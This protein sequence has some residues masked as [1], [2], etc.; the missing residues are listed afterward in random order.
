MAWLVDR[1]KGLF[2]SGKFD[3]DFWDSLEDLLIEAD[4]GAE[5]VFELVDELKKRS[6]RDRAVTQDDVIEILKDSVSSHIKAY[7]FYI[8]DNDFCVFLFLG[9]NG[10]GK[11][12]SIAKFSHYLKKTYDRSDIVLAAGDTF[13]AGAI[14]QLKIHGD[15][16]G[17]RV[18]AQKHGADPA[19]V[20]FDAIE[21]AR[22]RGERI[23][24]ADTAGR[25]HNRSSLMDELAKIDRIVRKKTEDAKYIKFL[26][27]DATTGQNAFRQ[28]EAFN[29]DIGVDAV[30]LTKF[31]ASAKG[32]IIVPVCRK[33]GVPVAFIGTGEK[34][35][36][37]MAFDRDFYISKLL[38]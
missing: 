3:E 16:L 30:I 29:Q 5:T 33:L 17:L 25:F 1:I 32:G 11:T 9:V 20:V 34:P 22:S 18:V 14:E 15:R 23:V 38:G 28:V 4:L 37:F 27:I 7:D 21:S 2:G 26:V 19:A 31:D 13:R 8:D 12:T 36:D 35:D 6:K 10:A 24:C